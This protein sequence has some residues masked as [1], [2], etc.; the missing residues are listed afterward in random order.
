VRVVLVQE[1]WWDMSGGTKRLTQVIADGTG[2]SESEVVLLA[3]G[4][5]CAAALVVVIRTY[6]TLVQ[7]WPVHAPKRPQH[8]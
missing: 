4:V 8:P 1:W 2:R 3:A 6:D 5:T 7:G